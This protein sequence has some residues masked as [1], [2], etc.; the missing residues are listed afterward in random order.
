M[1]RGVNEAPIPYDGRLLRCVRR[2]QERA[3]HA[4][5]LERVTREV[6][7][8]VAVERKTRQSWR[9]PADERDLRGIPA[10]GR[11]AGAIAGT[12][13]DRALMAK[14]PRE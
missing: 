2:E 10:I 4:K 3:E 7:G 13:P 11:V 14:Q 6:G 9:A 12:V 1:S 8:D 5:V